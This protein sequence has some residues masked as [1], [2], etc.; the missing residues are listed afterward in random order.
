MKG[1]SKH[2][3]P[4]ALVI[5]AL[6][7]AG[8]SYQVNKGGGDNSGASAQ[9]LNSFDALSASV[10]EPKC[11]SCHS[12][13]NA[14]GGVDLSNYQSIMSNPGLVVAGSPN[15]SR[16]FTEV[17]SGDMPENGPALPAQEVQ[18]IQ[19]WILAGAPNGDFPPSNPS[20]APSAPGTPAPE[21]QPQPQP[22][23]T[24]RTTPVPQPVV[25]T[26]SQVQN[27]ILTQACIQCH[28]GSRPSGRVDLTSFKAIMANSKKLAVAG[29]AAHSLLYTEIK[30]GSMPPR[31]KLSQDLITLMK[32][33][34]N[35][36]A[37]NN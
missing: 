34:I 17:Q 21:P 2:S 31:G 25:A 23:P 4:S 8:C 20:Q 11:V 19:D 7:M 22:Q 27:R 12:A 33:W 1:I 15:A 6:A 18:A 37:K 36:G 24:P 26:Y 5:F 9:S 10:F 16:V 14:S 28:S 29:D 13:S 30:S 3:K 35:D 32:D